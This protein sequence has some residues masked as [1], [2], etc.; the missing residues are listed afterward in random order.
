M[1]IGPSIFMIVVGTI[2][3]YAITVHISGV[4]LRALG[5]ILAVAGIVTLM[6]RLVWLFNPG[7]GD[8]EPPR[9]ATPDGWSDGPPP[10]HP[11]APP[12]HTGPENWARS[13]Y[14]Q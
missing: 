11:P 2:L 1:T 9:G 7:L 13:S 10:R 8:R 14:P 3:R 5:L 6:L 4:N 12:A